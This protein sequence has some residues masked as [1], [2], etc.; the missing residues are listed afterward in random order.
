[1]G[2]N[3][4][5]GIRM[6][7]RITKENSCLRNVSKITSNAQERMKYILRILL[8]GERMIY[9]MKGE[10]VTSNGPRLGWGP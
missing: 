3:K 8:G 10:K 7:F 2:R 9:R 5:E 6:C 4:I 1:M